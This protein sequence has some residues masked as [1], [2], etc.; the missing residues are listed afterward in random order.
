MT[1]P[2][3][4]TPFCKGFRIH[5]LQFF[6]LAKHCFAN[7]TF[8]AKQLSPK[9]FH[10]FSTF[11]IKISKSLFL[12]KT[13]RIGIRSCN[14]LILLHSPGFIFP[15]LH[16]WFLM[17]FCPQKTRNALALRGSRVRIPPSPRKKESQRSV[18]YNSFF[19]LQP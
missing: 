3:L 14:P 2:Y 6:K 7:L 15:Y 11:F 1:S 13:A 12:R 8:C 17:V 16:P 18:R 19:L 9:Y 5:C 10:T 4:F